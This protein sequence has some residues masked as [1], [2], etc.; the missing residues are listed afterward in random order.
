MFLHMLLYKLYSFLNK[1]LTTWWCPNQG[2]P[3]HVFA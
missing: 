2:R 3:K 1:Y